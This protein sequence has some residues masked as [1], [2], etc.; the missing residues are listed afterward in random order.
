[1]PS[2]QNISGG[3]PRSGAAHDTT[4][5]DSSHAP[6]AKKL[7]YSSGKQNP[8]LKD[9]ISSRLRSGFASGSNFVAQKFQAFLNNIRSAKA[10]NVSA[11]PERVAS[12]KA[13]RD[14]LVYELKQ[15]AGL[16][17][18]GSYGGLEMQKDFEYQADLII[19]R[20]GAFMTGLTNGSVNKLLA[21]L[22]EAYNLHPND[23]GDK[24][25]A[26]HELHDKVRMNDV[27]KSNVFQLCGD[28]EEIGTQIEKDL[29]PERNY[30]SE[31]L[32][33]AN[34]GFHLAVY[35]LYE[36]FSRGELYNEGAVHKLVNRINER[37]EFVRKEISDR[38]HD[39]WYSDKPA[40]KQKLDRILQKMKAVTEKSQDLASSI[41]PKND[42]LDPD[43]YFENSSIF[44]SQS[45]DAAHQF[46][47]DAAQTPVFS[48][49]T[50]PA[51]LY[52]GQSVIG[53]VENPISN[54]NQDIDYLKDVMA[55]YQTSSGAAA[56]DPEMLSALRYALDAAR[57]SYARLNAYLMQN[58]IKTLDTDQF[59]L[60]RDQN[61]ARPHQDNSAAPKF[62]QLLSGA[63]MAVCENDGHMLRKLSAAVEALI[64]SEINAHSVADSVV[65]NEEKDRPD[66]KHEAYNEASSL[67]EEAMIKQALAASL[68][69]V[70]F[71][72]PNMNIIRSQDENVRMEATL[73]N[74]ND[75]VHKKEDSK[76]SYSATHPA[77]SERSAEQLRNP[78]HS[79]NAQGPSLSQRSYV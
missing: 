71:A 55:A 18:N 49:L 48:P 3:L 63:D 2:I 11:P 31:R 75:L 51:P 35:D 30:Y 4:I 34:E 38:E 21:S 61:I 27:I 78:N 10:T 36:S 52:Q 68:R 62:S 73:E 54:Y 7:L 6:D 13:M 25:P 24:F 39:N 64:G 53:N 23:I 41:L 57:T 76:S 69:E 45:P 66:I 20:T 5:N 42:R 26:I 56:P 74:D 44:M 19:G 28:F 12:V 37:V 32:A 59:S 17:P 77:G 47:S 50:N 65:Q 67:D 9:N 58:G 60:V 70:G 16:D 72:A 43:R 46:I 15:Q 14:A 40:E 33:R 22:A 8:S 29:S 79:A 1:M